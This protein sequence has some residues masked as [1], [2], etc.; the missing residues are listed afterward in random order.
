[1]S[2]DQTPNDR[3]AALPVLLSQ[4]RE[5]LA[6]SGALGDPEADALLAS[7]EECVVAA[8]RL[9]LRRQIE[10]ADG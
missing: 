6:A 4:A 3:L 7:L 2:E 1:M 10:G 8:Y 5:S 9:I